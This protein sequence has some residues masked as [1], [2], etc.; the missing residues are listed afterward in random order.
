MMRQ[1]GGRLLRNEL[2]R[3]FGKDVAL[4]LGCLVLL[5][6]M[7]LKS[8]RLWGVGIRVLMQIRMMMLVVL[9]L[10]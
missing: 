2:I 4:A 3:V 6:M 8:V 1:V 9:L 10:R 7:R 5:E